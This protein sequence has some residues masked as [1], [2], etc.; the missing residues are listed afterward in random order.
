VRTSAEGTTVRA[1]EKARRIITNVHN[2]FVGVKGLPT[3]AVFVGQNVDLGSPIHPILALNSPHFP[4]SAY[5]VSVFVGL[6]K[7]S[8]R[9]E[10]LRTFPIHPGR[11]LSHEGK[12]TYQPPGLLECVGIEYGSMGERTFF[13]YTPQRPHGAAFS[14]KKY[15]QLSRGRLRNSASENP[16][17]SCPCVESVTRRA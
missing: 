14:L 8:S 6:P 16:F 4:A 7:S 10:R 17:L 2:L 9:S 13:S 11:C 3:Q 12:S 5:P 1:A 15:A